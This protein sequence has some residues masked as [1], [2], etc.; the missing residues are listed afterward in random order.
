[1]SAW[2]DVTDFLSGNSGTTAAADQLNQLPDILRQYYNPYINAGNAEISPYQSTI[3]NLMQNP[4]GFVNNIMQ[5]YQPSQMYQNNMK[6]MQTASNNAAAAGG[7][8]GTGEQVQQVQQNANNLSMADQSQYLQQI[9]QPFYQGLS[10]ASNIFG[11]GYNASNAMATD[12]TNNNDALAQN[13]YQ[14][15]QNFDNAGMKGAAAIAAMF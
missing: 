15:G 8:L 14:R 7:T 11:T 1:M 4:T 12:L 9:L 2:T 3:N 13:A 5:S 6:S 10:G